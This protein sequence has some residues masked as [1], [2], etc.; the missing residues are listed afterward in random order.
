MTDKAL[1]RRSLEAVRT[2]REQV[3]ELRA[4]AA[5]PI[6]VVGL[7]CR[8]PGGADG[9]ERFWELLREGRDGVVDVPGD[10]W[11]VEGWYSS[12]RNEPGTS[13]TRRGG[14]LAEGAHAFDAGFFGITDAEARD[15]DPQHR[16]LLET[17]WQALESAGLLSGTTAERRVGVFVGV[18]GSENTLLPRSPRAAGPYTATGS[19]ISVAAGRI[20]HTFGLRGPALAV[21]TACSS[22]LL[23][24]HLAVESL[25]RGECTAALAGGVSA[26]MSPAVMV[27]LCRMEALAEDGKCKVF[28]AAADGYV[29]SEGSGMVALMRASDAA[30]VRAPVLAL[31]RGSAVNHD[32]RTSGLTVPNGRAQRELIADAVA[33]AGVEPRAVDYLEAHGTGTAL[34]DPIEVRA[35]ADVLC[36]DRDPAAPLRIG[37]VK[38]NIGHLEAAAGVAGLIK[39]VLALR[40]GEL[41]G[42]LHLNEPN[43]R[44]GV[45]RLPVALC[46][47][48]ATWPRHA[49]GRAR[50]AGV[51]SF[52]FSGTNVHVVLTEPDA[53]PP[54][55]AGPERPAHVFALSARDPEGLREAAARHGQWLATHPDATLADFCHTATARRAH[56][57]HRTAF[58]TASRDDLARRLAALAAGE[59]PEPAA[60]PRQTAAAEAVG[61]RDRAPAPPVAFLLDATAP[62]AER[63]TETLYATHPGFR[64]HV[65]RC[66]AELRAP[67]AESDG[68]PAA[69]AADVRTVACQIALVRTLADWGIA[70][71]A[72]AG[73]AA[74]GDLAAAVLSGALDAPTAGALLA[75]RHGAAAPPAALPQR[76]RALRLLHGPDAGEAGADQAADPGFWLRTGPGVRPEAAAAALAA[77][78]YDTLVHLGGPAGRHAPGEVRGLPG[79]DIWRELLGWLADRHVAG[80]DVDWSACDD[81][82]ERTRLDLPGQTFRRRTHRPDA[83]ALDAAPA[84]SGAGAP[85]GA[86]GLRQVA[87]P[88]AQRQYTADV[89]RAA[90]PEV[91]DTAGV[92]H[93]GY[94]QELLAAAAGTGPGLRL[95]DV[96]FERALTLA[97]GQERTV[98]LAVGPADG[99]GWAEFSVHSREAGDA[100]PDTSGD[101]GWH[102]HA[103]GRLRPGGG[104][105]E[106]GPLPE[107]ARAEIRER[108]PVRFEGAEFYRQMAERGVPLGPSVEWVDEAWLGE[109]EV[110]ARFRLPTPAET[111]TATGRPERALPVPAGMLDACVQLYALAAGPQLAER[112]LFMTARLG[113]VGFGAPAEGTLWCHVRLTAPVGELLVGEHLLCAEDGAA[114]GWGR[115]TEISVISPSTGTYETPV[116]DVRDDAARQRFHGPDG[117]AALR[118]LLTGMVAELLQLPPAE[119]PSGRPLAETGLDSLAALELRQRV[120]AETGVDLPV[121]LLIAGPS[122]DEVVERLCGSVA[123]DEPAAPRPYDVDGRLWLPVTPQ[124]DA[125]V[126]LFCLPYGGRGAS[127]YRDWPGGADAGVEV[128]PVQLPGREERADERCLADADEAVD[129]VAQALKPYLDRPFAFYGHSMGA[130]LAYR[131]AHRLGAEYGELLRHLFVGAFSAPTGGE[132]PLGARLRAVT[133]RLGYEQMPEHEELARVRRAQPRLYDTALRAE[134]GEH[135]AGKA[136]V[137]MDGAGYSDLRVVQSYRHDP[138]EAPLRVPVT[139]F[140]GAGDPVVAE[141]DADGWRPL[142]DAGFELLVVPGDHFFVHGDQSGARV[143]AEM[144]ARLRQP[145]RA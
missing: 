68:A 130:L 144:A 138:A 37:A 17:S 85:M 82:Y 26:M 42:G 95:D 128:V 73:G 5:E 110:L 28:D 103:A 114:V 118:D 129:A 34:G 11:P 126:R 59:G 88:L 101:E 25:R 98:H 53:Q 52:G 86:L 1:L 21:D 18:S 33:A 96:R 39:T 29:R 91:A 100:S 20:A 12:D 58:V 93:V 55:P 112:D 137:A 13:Y 14:F 27:A 32:G 143:L 4:R 40:H 35:A 105:A 6:A 16:L 111:G 136:D 10:R 56:F 51:S 74:P 44:L 41:P 134:L 66:T 80:Q 47:R 140:H 125:A 99:D 38:S 116:D 30:A 69:L 141:Q 64:A 78:G 77:H 60:V 54:R 145:V 63:I 43:P 70:A 120:R 31:I 117:A 132:N 94:Y 87:S 107:A 122:L 113:E 57:A 92:L 24:V 127:L 22:S 19:A 36:T 135:L 104:G 83:A 84:A 90:L 109:G 71:G 123:G 62:A 46:D 7:G 76:P 48:T 124:D 142:T 50:T 119:V 49:D 121:D 8:F 131:L 45:E 2:L 67:A 133:Q 65:D 72:V 23:A 75:A 115:G 89:S 108:C 15:M 3:D 9:P 61:A 97:R 79:D 106:P 81:G 102:R 139:A